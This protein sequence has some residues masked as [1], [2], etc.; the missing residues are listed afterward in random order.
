[1][2]ERFD[3]II[4]GGSYAGLAAALQ[5]VRARR[6]VLIIDAGERRNRFAAHSHGFLG[7]D[8]RAPGDIAAHGRAEVLAYP[9]ASWHEGA[10][11]TVTPDGEHFV[12]ALAGGEVR[13]A[14]RVIL[15]TGMRDDVSAIPGVAERW[16]KQAFPCPYCD[17]YELKQGRIGV[18]ASVPQATHLAMMLPDWGTTTLLANGIAEPDDETRAAL[19]RRGVT[20]E[21]TLVEAVTGDRDIEVRLRDGRVLA[22][23]GLFVQPKVAPAGPL[24]AQLGLALQDGPI[25][26]IVQTDPMTKETS[27]RGV[28]A[29][30][31]VAMPQASVSF[32]VADGA[33]AGV[34]AH[35][36]LV[37]R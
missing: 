5:L 22:F 9:T 35:Q 21:S 31:D 14:R 17:G 25:Y 26:R 30:G 36:S 33:R 18:L 29:C 34:G 13:R 4:V 37:F 24:V 28:F 23:D 20:I 2:S 3:V 12:V 7:Q 32:A 6:R 16:G 1:M 11:Q 27:V 10:V 15:A 19:V 8:G